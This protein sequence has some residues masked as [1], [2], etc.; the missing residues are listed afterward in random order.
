L[1]V[2]LFGRWSFADG[3]FVDLATNVATTGREFFADFTK[4]HYLISAIPVGGE[5]GSSSLG[6]T[7]LTNSFAL[8]MTSGASLASDGS[9]VGSVDWLLSHELFHE[10]NGHVIQ[11]AQPEQL[12]YWFSEGF[13]DFYARRLLYR[14]GRIGRDEYVASWNSKLQA[15]AANPARAVPAERVRE[16]FWSDRNVGEVPYQRGDLVAL[17]V[18]AAIRAQSR[19]ERSL[20][21][22]MRALVARGHAGAPPFDTDG[23]C[24]VIAE[25]AGRATADAVMRWALEGQEAPLESD[26]LGPE[27]ELVPATFARFETGFDHEASLASGTV[28][29]VHPG[30]PA[31]RAGLR[32]GMHVRSWSIRHGAPEQPIVLRV[33]EA[34][35][36]REISYLPRGTDVPGHRL[37]VR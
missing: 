17:F 22:L 23:L 26:A 28:R 25:F 3:E 4:P 19:G 7:G 14:S 9:G 13:T 11:L 30:G 16:A 6:G 35:M 2:A 15:F 32:D 37:R 36:E 29:G 10:W 5:P 24:D 33:R 34:G 20:D 18:D 21:E 8:F 27:F 1:W 12:C 31:E